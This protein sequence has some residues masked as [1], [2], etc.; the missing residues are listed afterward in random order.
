MDGFRDEESLKFYAE[1]VK[2]R[3]EQE[4]EKEEED[5]FLRSSLRR[6]DRLGAIENYRRI[7]RQGDAVNRSELN[8]AFEYDEDGLPSRS[9][10]LTCQRFSVCRPKQTE[11]C[12]QLLLYIL[13]FCHFSWSDLIK[14]E[15]WKS[16][17]ITVTG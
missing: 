7:I 13:I 9:G 6:S 3:I 11:V 8:E 4:K 14:Y 2:K 17:N 10:N 1:E 5:K 12:L 16:I 15:R